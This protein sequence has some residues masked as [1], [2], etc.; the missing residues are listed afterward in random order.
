MFNFVVLLEERSPNEISIISQIPKRI[1]IPD[2]EII[3]CLCF[4]E[5]NFVNGVYVFNTDDYYFYVYS[6]KY[7]QNNNENDKKDSVKSAIIIITSYLRPNLYLNF[8]DSIDQTFEQMNVESDG[9][10]RFGLVFSL[11]SSW[12]T[13]NDGDLLVNYP[14]GVFKIILD[15]FNYWTTSFGV[16][17]LCPYVENAWTSFLSNQGV[18]FICPDP[19]TCTAAIAA[20][21]ALIEPVSCEEKMMLY[22]N[23]DD[24]RFE[25]FLNGEYSIAATTDES[26]FEKVSSKFGYV[27]KI[28]DSFNHKNELDKYLKNCIETGASSKLKKKSKTKTNDEEDNKNKNNDEIDLKTFFEQ[29]TYRLFRVL[30]ATMNMK[31]LNDPYFDILEKEITAQDIEGLFPNE[32]K[33]EIIEGI[34]KTRTFKKWRHRK[35]D[36]EQVRAAFLSATPQEAVEKIPEDIGSLTLCLE[37]LNKILCKFNRD[38]HLS[39]VIKHNISL[40][41]KKLKKLKKNST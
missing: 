38:L 19:P 40:V 28:N 23:K 22:T 24:P 11:L 29:K 32:F 36:R 7:S 5:D 15:D 4:S 6:F 20:L 18:L 27:L 9:L 21:L 16:D 14:Q 34:Q 1:E 31:V 13:D 33:K 8:L 26:V 25:R 10:C 12:S 35:V 3:K 17:P 30:I 39:T 37:E 2:F 41:Q